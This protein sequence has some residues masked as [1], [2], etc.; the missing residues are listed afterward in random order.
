MFKFSK[1]LPL[2]LGAGFIFFGAQKFGAE[3]AVFEIIAERS[4]LSFFEPHIRRLTG[5]VEL[6]A[7]LLLIL[8]SSRKLGALFGLTILLGAVGFHLSPWLG[9]NVPGIGHGLF[10]TALAMTALNLALIK[11]YFLGSPQPQLA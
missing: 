1:Y 3:N 2:L 5:V 8:P 7:G 10:F 4:G 9:I 6:V 11:Q